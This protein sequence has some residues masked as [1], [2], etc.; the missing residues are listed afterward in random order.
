M[1]NTY[2][3]A[4]QLSPKAREE[5]NRKNRAYRKSLRERRRA[6]RPPVSPR[7]QLQKAERKR[8]LTR[9]RGRRYRARLREQQRT[10]DLSTPRLI[11]ALPDA[12][13]DAAW[14]ALCSTCG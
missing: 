7:T 13:A 3:P 2:V 10:G 6:T 14:E 8:A 9:E 4:D 5:R 1:P 12:V 11:A